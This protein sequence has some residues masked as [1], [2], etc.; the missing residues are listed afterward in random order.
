[1]QTRVAI[2]FLAVMV[3]AQTVEGLL[4]FTNADSP[5]S[6]QEI[7][8]VIR[9]VGDLSELTTDV[10]QRTLTMRATPDQLAL[11]NWIAP[12]STCRRTHT[13]AP[14]RPIASPAATT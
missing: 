11:A 8:T 1:M 4:R 9:S 5:Q 3:Q 14:H 2:T 6:L 7:A 10:K 13:E 12:T